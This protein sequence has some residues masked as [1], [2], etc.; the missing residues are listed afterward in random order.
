MISV[1]GRPFCICSRRPC[2]D[3]RQKQRARK[4]MK[5]PGPLLSH[6]FSEEE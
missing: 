6:V 4:T 1:F 5:V 2:S 3:S